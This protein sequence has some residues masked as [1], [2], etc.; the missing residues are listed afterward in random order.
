MIL[1][2]FI[3]PCAFCVAAVA[4][5]PHANYCLDFDGKFSGAV[6][7]FASGFQSL[8]GVSSYTFEAWVRPRSQGGGGRGRILDQE[9]SSLT[10]Y[11][12]D[13]GRVGF[14]PNRDSGWQLSEAN[15]IQFWKWQHVAV[16]SDGKFLRFF[17]DGKLRTAIPTYT[18]LNITRKPVRI[19]TGI[20]EDNTTR[21]FDGWIDDIRISDICRWTSD[22]IP[23][24]RGQYTAPNANTV[25]YLPFDDGLAQSV[26]LDY[27]T[28][29][30]EIKIVEPLRRVRAPK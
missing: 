16:S 22:F 28:Y 18:T 13:E 1:R 21:G 19:G 2:R 4:A 7:D 30:G 12:S 23:P 17:V 27:S 9:G 11:L 20:G 3:I 14:R 8:N 10:F 15:S 25:L 5:E 26:A 24:Q 29:N 6:L